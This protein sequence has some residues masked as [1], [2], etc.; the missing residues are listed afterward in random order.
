MDKIDNNST[1]AEVK[2]FLAK[3]YEKG[4]ICSACG[5]NVKMYKK[6]IDSLMAVYLIKLYKLSNGSSGKYFHV[7][8]DLDVPLKVGG[9]W[10]KLRWWGLI[11]EQAKDELNTTSRTSGY[12]KITERGIHY[13]KGE[14]TLPKYVKLYNGKCR[15]SEGKK[16]T[17]QESLGDKFNYQELM[18]A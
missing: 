12:W 6:K 18:N 8:N 11:E 13:A 3:H 7:E 9:S 17:I 2:A 1:L 5:Q 14:I 15:G 4:C 16:T 10:A